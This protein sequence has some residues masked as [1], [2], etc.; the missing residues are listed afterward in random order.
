MR[1]DGGG[2]RRGGRYGELLWTTP[3]LALVP[4]LDTTDLCVLAGQ[5]TRNAEGPGSTDVR[6]GEVV[7]GGGAGD[8]TYERMEAV[9]VEAVGH[10]LTYRLFG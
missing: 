2:R 4:T 8:A 5:A 9:D 7:L 10:G 6:P 3:Y 1:E